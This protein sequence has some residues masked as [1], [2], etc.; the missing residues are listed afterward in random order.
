[1]SQRP[2]QPTSADLRK[3]RRLIRAARAAAGDVR[4]AGGDLRAAA[5]TARKACAPTRD[6]QLTVCSPFIRLAETWPTL[7]DACRTKA[8]ERL[9][10][11]AE[12]LAPHV[13]APKAKATS[14]TEAAGRPLSTDQGERQPRLDIYG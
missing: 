9:V 13:G 10:A 3:W 14:M 6:L 8:A 1:M 4:G 12:Q 11:F 7:G 5:A 2:L